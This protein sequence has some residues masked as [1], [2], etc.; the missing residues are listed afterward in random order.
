MGFG[1]R[2]AVPVAVGDPSFEEQDERFPRR[3]VALAPDTPVD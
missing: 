2:S 3:R 1:S